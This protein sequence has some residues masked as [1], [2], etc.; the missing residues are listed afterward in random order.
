MEDCISPFTLSSKWKT[1][2]Q[3]VAFDKVLPKQLRTQKLS[4][5]MGVDNN[6]WS[7][8]LIEIRLEMCPKDTDA[9]A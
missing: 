7:R 3:F 2:D 8:Q 5:H 6:Y 9:P 1:L 4:M